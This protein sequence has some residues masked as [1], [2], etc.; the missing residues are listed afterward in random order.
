MRVL[1]LED[2]RETLDALR[3]GLVNE[4]HEIAAAADAPAALALVDACELDA[5]V[6]DLG[7]PGGSGFDV[8][9][10]LK[11]RRP[12]A[13]VLLLTARGEVS[14]R[15]AGLDRG[16]D[17]YLV[18]PFSFAELA[19]RLRAFERRRQDAVTQLVVGEL[20]LDLLRRHALAGGRRIDLTPLEFGL[21]AALVRAHG[22][23]LSR[24]SLLREIWGYDFDPG[25][26]VV[27]VHVNRVRRKLEAAGV[28]DLVRTVRGRGYAVGS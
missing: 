28:R 26:N 1:V 14:D 23:P 18:K 21:L 20:H 27:E 17:D 9:A 3:S 6:L 16:A 8:L 5:A 19:A 13:R 12:S 22:E 4:G 25:T 2:D 7:V 11:L 10:Q 15:V 24:S